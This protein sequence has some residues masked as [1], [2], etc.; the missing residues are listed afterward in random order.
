[1][2]GAGVVFGIESTD[3]LLLG[4]EYRMRLTTG[5]VLKGVVEVKDDTSLVLESDGKPYRFR[6]AL[7][8]DYTMLK[9]PKRLEA[10]SAPR[11]A[12]GITEEEMITYEQL[13]YR[14]ISAGHIEVRINH[15]SI[16]RGTVAAVDENQLRLDVDGSVIPIAREVIQQIAI[17]TPESTQEVAARPEQ[18]AAPDV[19]DSVY[20]KSTET[21]E[22]GKPLPP[23]LIVG[24][25]MPADGDGVAI[26]TRKGLVRNLESDR[27]ARV[28]RHSASSYEDKIKRYAKPLICPSGMALVDLPPGREG[29]PFFKVC[30][31]TYEYPNVKGQEP[32]G[33]VSFEEAREACASAGKRLCSAEEW[34]WACS[35]VEGYTYPYGWH[36]EEN[37][38]NTRGA[39]HVEPSG[40]R[41]KCLGKFGVYDMVGNVFEWVVGE[42]GKP[43]LMGGPYSKCQTVSPGV[44]GDAKPQTGFRCCKSN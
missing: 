14:G 8:L 36:F 2:L 39:T 4:G 10:R 43:M 3:A 28:I 37:F 19:L 26:R 25:L 30:I 33:N 7:I 32:R 18:P 16:F 12:G 35:G 27:V 21:D 9:P 13:V 38:C 11:P 22:Y 40:A 6:A 41:Q 29:R 31:D 24:K 44:G 23:V 15:G 1:M 17:Y 34:Q 42:G 5:D 20:V